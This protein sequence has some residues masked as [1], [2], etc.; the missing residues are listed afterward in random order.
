VIRSAIGIPTIGYT[1]QAKFYYPLKGGIQALYNAA[2]QRAL[3]KGVMLEGGKPVESI[4][5]KNDILINNKYRTKKVISTI[6]IPELINSIEGKVY[7]DLKAFITK[8][9]YNSV[10]VVAVAVG[11]EAPKTHWIYVPDENI[12]FHRY[13]WVSNYSPYNA[14][15]GKSLLLAEITITPG[16]FVDERLADIVVKDLVRLGVVEEK[17]ILFTRIWFHEYGYPIHR[18]GTGEA[19]DYVTKYMEELRITLAGR[20]GTWRYLNM[21]MVMKHVKELEDIIIMRARG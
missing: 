4:K 10:A 11:R 18:I 20:W 5:A 19:R 2:K 1:E 16:Q 8:F 17:E 15:K 14:P 6:P 9:D 3:E 12:V 13:T 21:D 7:D